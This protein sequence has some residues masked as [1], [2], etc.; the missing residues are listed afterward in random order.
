M[1]IRYT[2]QVEATTPATPDEAHAYFSRKLRC[3]T[4]AYDVHH[5]L[6]RG[7]GSFVVLDVRSHAD[8]LV[9][10]VPGA[11]SL[12]YAQI[13][14][15]RLREFPDDTLFVVYCWGPGCNG[16]TKAAVRLSALGYAVKEML[17]GI[18][19]WQREGYAIAQGSGETQTAR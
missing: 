1:T 17:G 7:I 9:A 6:S 13:S 18:E 4:D 2:S 10:H 12:P 16:A 8:Y 14:E 11:I 5:D 15:A 19:Y 3:E